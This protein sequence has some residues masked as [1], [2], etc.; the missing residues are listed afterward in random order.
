MDITELTVHELIEKI[1]NKEL[2]VTEINQAYIDRI[3]L[4]EKDIQAFITVLDKEA[5]ERSKKYFKQFV[6]VSRNSNRY[7]R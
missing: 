5:L 7:K 1:K 3:N 6:R 4:R 2:T